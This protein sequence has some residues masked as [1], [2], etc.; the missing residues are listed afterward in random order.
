M[1]KIKTLFIFIIYFIFLSNVKALSNNILNYSNTL[2]LTNENKVVD[3][4]G[5]SKNYFI[6]TQN[7]TNTIIYKYTYDNYLISTKEFQNLSSPK[8]IEYNNNYILV[9]KE[10]NNIK[11]YYIDNNL[12]I[13]SQN[14]SSIMISPL[15]DINLYINNNI[16]YIM[17]TNQNTLYDNQIYE[18]DQEL[19][20]TSNNLSTYNSNLLK[21]IL[22]SDYY[23]IH[24]N[25][26]IIDNNT[27]HYNKTTYTN[28]DNIL[29]GTKQTT[30]NQN[31]AI[32]TI[33]N[34]QE[35][36]IEYQ[37]YTNFYDIKLINDKYIIIAKDLQEKYYLLTIDYEGN[38]NDSEL[39][40]SQFD[41]LYKVGNKLLVVSNYES[42]IK[43]YDYQLNI[44]YT[45]SQYSTIDIPSTSLA[46]TN[47]KLN[48][49]T[50][51]GYEIAEIKIVD[52]QGN[53]IIA[54]NN[55]FI[56]PQ[57]DVTI[58]ISYKETVTNPETVDIIMIITTISIIMIALLIYSR[59]KLK[60]LN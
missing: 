4:I 39:L 28:K 51:S 9:G 36:T 30:D 34:N 29:I 47:V 11:V 41:Q 37:E 60:W 6:I 44:K 55:E 2:T 25:D 35:K 58:D 45:K 13:L 15:A 49:E 12:K 26:N 54:S 43:Y 33:F 38:I 27:Y 3:I 59:K 21:E 10:S 31:I 42:L 7:T 56:M 20:I 48:I 32:L 19:N 8:I 23:L 57:N 5:N 53:I 50:N 46:Y 18:I 16:I 17:L 1:K 24:N 22:H 14:D 52:E 40:N